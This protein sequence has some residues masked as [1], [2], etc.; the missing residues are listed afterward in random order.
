MNIKL[1]NKNKDPGKKTSD[2]CDYSCKYADFSNPAS[3]GA[4]RKELSVY[5][6][7]V[8]KYNLKNSCCLLKKEEG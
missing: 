8:K 1:S 5:C 4:C 2:F 7:K 6:K 3:I